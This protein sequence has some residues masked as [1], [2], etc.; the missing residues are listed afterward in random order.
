M[1]KDVRVDVVDLA[2]GKLPVALRQ[3]YEFNLTVPDRM[4][5][6]AQ[7]LLIND[8]NDPEFIPFAV[9]SDSPALKVEVADIEDG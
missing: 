6:V 8:R 3:K 9:D 5:K 4:L 7:G 2:Q 1:T